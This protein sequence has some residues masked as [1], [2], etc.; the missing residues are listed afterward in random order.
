[1]LRKI[2]PFLA[3]L[4]SSAM[5]YEAR[6]VKGEIAASLKAVLVKATQDTGV[7]FAESDF[8][9]I[10][11]RQLATSTFAM[12]VQAV[13]GV[14]VSGTAIRFWIKGSNEVIQAEVHLDETAS[15]EKT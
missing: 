13:E 10:E 8:L 2:L 4:S 5:A 11:T 14:P 6:Y 1:M 9:Q 7:A 12:W 15:V 3:L